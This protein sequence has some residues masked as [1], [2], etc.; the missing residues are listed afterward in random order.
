MNK[1]REIIE[2]RM[3][4]MG[5]KSLKL[6]GNRLR[7]ISKRKSKKVLTK[8]IIQPDRNLNGLRISS[9]KE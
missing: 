9:D 3:L 1:L 5:S 6:K 8:H 2:T 4:L 7:I